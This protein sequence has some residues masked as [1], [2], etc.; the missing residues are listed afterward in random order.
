MATTAKKKREKKEVLPFTSDEIT[1]ERDYVKHLIECKCILPHLQELEPII[2]HKFI[3]FSE[4]EPV[5]ANIVPSY[6]QCNNCGVIHRVTEVG[7]TDVLRKE[8]LRTLAN[9]E[10]IEL[11]LPEKLSGI[12][13]RHECELHIWQEARFI[14]Q[15]K[16]YGRFLVLEKEKEGSTVIGKALMIF[17]SSIFRVE[18]FEREEGLI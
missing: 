17:G 11:E 8:E 5:T 3:V 15:H 16:L 1:N 2:F 12:L 4:L 9:I 6:A 7:T 14:L 13:K 18:T 10:D